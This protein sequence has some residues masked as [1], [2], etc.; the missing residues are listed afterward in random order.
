MNKNLI[1]ALGCAFAAGT[2]AAQTYPSMSFS[3]YGTL[4]AAS[5]NESRGDYLVDAF[6]PDGPGYTDKVSLKVDSRVGGQAMAEFSPKLSAVLQVLVQQDYDD[7]WRPRV[8]WA[9]LKYQVT[10]ELSLRAGR[11]VLPVF[12]VTDSR[13][14]GY[15]N[16]WVRPPVELYSLVPVT[17]SDGADATWRVPIGAWNNS[18]QVTFGRSNSHFPNASGFDAGV[19]EARRIFAFNDTVEIGPFTGRVSLGE[20]RLTIEAYQPLFDAFRQF[21]A[22]GGNAI[23]DRYNV[24]DRRVTFAGFGATYDPGTWFV[25]AEWARFDTHSIVGRKSAGYVSAGPRLGK[26]TP[27]ATYARLKGES[28][29]SDPGLP[30][31]IL[32]PQVAPLAAQANGVLNRQLS[33]LPDQSTI[34]LGMR[35]DFMRSAAL[36]VQWD[37]IRLGS[38]SYGTFGNIQPDFPFGGNVNVYSAVV[39]FVF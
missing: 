15:G 24:D 31:A 21:G 16:P 22:V 18:L 38:G 19:A 25:M 4:G 36:K 1:F 33:A 27:Y 14:V 11:I 35:W 37:R 10:D 34:S 26:F 5:S 12:M 17:N 2:A 8:E 13:R 32:P 7:R 3:G 9:N 6:K 23:A 20:A 39:D 30:L 29:R 28:P